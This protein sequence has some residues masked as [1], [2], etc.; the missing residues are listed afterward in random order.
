MDGG[1]AV[2]MDAQREGWMNLEEKH[3]RKENER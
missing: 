3:T 1:W 2:R